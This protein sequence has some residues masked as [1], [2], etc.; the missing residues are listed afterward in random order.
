MSTKY[1]EIRRLSVAVA[2]ANAVLFSH[3]A[4]AQL[5]EVIV[6]A[7]KRME[8][9][10]DVPTCSGVEEI[11]D[12]LCRLQLLRKFFARVSHL[13]Q[14]NFGVSHMIEEYTRSVVENI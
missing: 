3:S 1:P 12:G 6:T 13:G 2:L 10:Q 4:T 7:Q 5:Q 14:I 11:M 9:A 8:S